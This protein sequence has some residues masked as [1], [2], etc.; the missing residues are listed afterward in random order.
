M[1][2]ENQMISSCISFDHSS[3][4]VSSALFIRTMHTAVHI[5]TG[6]TLAGLLTPFQRLV[7]GSGAKSEFMCQDL[8]AAKEA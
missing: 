3:W 4:P 2:I 6:K 1:S 8:D 5:L 7:M